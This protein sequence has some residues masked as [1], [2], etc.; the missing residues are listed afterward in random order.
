MT[1]SG[2]LLSAAL[3][4]EAPA[5]PPAPAAGDAAPRTRYRTRFGHCPS[6][7]AGALALDL[8]GVFERTRSLRGVKRAILEGGLDKKHFLSSYTVSHDP[9]AGR[10]EFSFQCPRPLMRVQIYKDDDLTPY[11]AVLVETGDLYDPSY[12]GLLRA[13][14]RLDH[15]LA[16]LAL[17]VGEMD[18]EAQERVTDLILS[19]GDAFRRTISEVILAENGNLTIIMSILGRPSSVFVGSGDWDEKVV[20]LR[21]LVSYVRKQ[22]R[23][24][25]I[26]NLV[27]PKK[28]VVK[29]SDGT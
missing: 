19:V 16:H 4:A 18:E 14:G 23:V 8:V 11:E 10:L 25:A 22:R 12:E 9:L 7:S 6:R 24:P 13:E 17:P 3:L 21:R 29:F 1:P 2:L 28:V 5:P 20:K 26:I 27:N 15:D